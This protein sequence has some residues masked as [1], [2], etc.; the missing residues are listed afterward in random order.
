VASPNAGSRWDVLARWNALPPKQRLALALLTAAML[1][2]VALAALAQRDTRAA[3]FA[4]PLA[5]D[6]V[7][8]VVE[9]LAAWNVPFVAL[10][11]NVRVDAVRRNELLLK[12]SLSG[13]PHAHLGSSAEALAKAGPL[14]PQSVLDAQQREGLAGDL[15]SGLRG[16]AGVDDAQ[17]IVAPA[18]ETGF[19]DETPAATTASV[20][21]TLRRGAT[22]SRETL[23]GVRAFV[24]AGVP[25]LDPK[26]VAVLDD[27]GAALGD[28]AIAGSEQAQA[29]QASLQSVL[30][31]AFGAG[32]SIVRVHVAYDPRTREVRDVVRKPLGGRA[33]GALTNDER[34]KS[35]SKQYAKSTSSLDRG[36]EVRDE[37]VD[38]PPGAEERISVAVAIDAARH[39]D[40]A[41]VRSLA[42]GALGLASNLDSIHVEEVAF[43][44]EPAGT[45]N[46]TAAALAGAFEALAAPAIFAVAALAALRLG[47]KPLGAACAALVERLTLAQRARAVANFPPAHVRGALAGEPPHTAA[48][49]ISALPAAT[50]TAVLEMYPPEERAA[51][52]RRMSRAAAPAVP[53][54]ETVLRRG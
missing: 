44:H 35:A 24:A 7:A 4:T 54:Y 10:P 19:A 14:T 8:E 3:L 5:T 31:V 6:Q 12:L 27:R 37:R 1:A 43:P 13:V 49:I 51:I 29:L 42:V 45:A 22:L 39:A 47:V 50:A 52:V 36:S 20:R 21:L 25:G 17:V 46:V 16:V 23:E 26:G 9:R 18:R 53:D 38:T 30:D 40:L 41:K 11:D 34:F 2:A 32:S 33:I 48:A 15:A 28:G